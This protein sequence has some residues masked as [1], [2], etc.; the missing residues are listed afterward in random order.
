M[1]DEV[2]QI[3]GSDYLLQR[4]HG[5]QSDIERLY[6]QNRG[7][8]RGE[9][10][11]YGAAAW[12]NRHLEYMQLLHNNGIHPTHIAEIGVA[13][14]ARLV[15]NLM[16]TFNDAE[17]TVFELSQERIDGARNTLIELFGQGEVDRRV[18]F[19]VGDAG[20]T[21]VQAGT[22]F[23]LFDYQL[24][25]QHLTDDGLQRILNAAIT[26]STP[27]AVLATADLDFGFWYTRPTDMNN[28]E[29]VMLSQLANQAILD[30]RNEA[31]RDK[32]RHDWDSH[33]A[34]AEA[35]M[36]LSNGKFAHDLA[37]SRPP[38]V[39]EFNDGDLEV[40]LME[41]ILQH[42]CTIAPDMTEPMKLYVQA[43]REQKIVG[44]YPALFHQTF[45]LRNSFVA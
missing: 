1:G 29:D 41:N 34:H 45:R 13:P 11:E 21:M 23:D 35:I 27:N 38:H 26:T 3:S 37:L 7:R 40:D 2:N 5:G 22:Q 24:L 20:T 18:H 30:I 33:L 16:K 8:R 6:Y 17:I 42:L 25:D 14:D 31:Y 44:F 19:V 12:G 10:V 28:P 9:Q 43:L 32:G 15:E 39:V 36:K 4:L